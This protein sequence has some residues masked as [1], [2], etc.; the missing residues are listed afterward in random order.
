M[1]AEERKRY[2]R[3]LRDNPLLPQIMEQCKQVALQV[4]IGARDLQTREHCWQQIQVY[5]QFEVQLT[6]TVTEL[7]KERAP[8]NPEE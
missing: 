2:A 6:A 5:N 1:N 3:E 4:W 7:S 8:S